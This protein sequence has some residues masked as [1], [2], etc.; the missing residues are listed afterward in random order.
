MKRYRIEVFD[1]NT[2]G[3]KCFAEATTPD[4]YIDAL[5]ASESSLT[6]K[7]VIDCKRGDFA[8][9][10]IDGKV[11]YQG[12][13]SDLTVDG[14]K[15]EVKMHQLIDMLNTEV[16]ADVSLLNSQTIE[17]WMK[18]LL[19]ATF[20]G[21][22]TFEQL[23]NLIVTTA[24][25]TSGAH[26]ESDNGVYN[27]YDLALYFFKIYGVIFDV[28]FDVNTAAVTI[29]MRSVSP[30]VMKLDMRV[31]D[32]S[33]YEI[34]NSKTTDSPS[35]VVVR[36]E[37]DP[38]ESATYYWHPTDFSGTI[39]TDPSTNRVVPVITRCETVQVGDDTTFADESYAKAEEILYATRY[40]DLINVTIK[41]ESK[42][43]DDW[44]IG[45]LY[46]L[47]DGETSYNTILTG[48]HTINMLYVEL[49]FGY[50]RKRL[51]QILKMKRGN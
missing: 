2:L 22:D 4:I 38:T 30:S 32:V 7:G 46:T 29:A 43:I 1:R 13:V 26:A 27:L 6:C 15:T 47:Y 8:Q 42:L 28:S 18:D 48:I 11:Y 49:T 31:S 21:S 24:S 25:S 17:Q 9:I 33:E 5:V 3:Y 12:T 36:N 34:E 41:A 16:F 19:L 23:P 10:R 14:N 20:K 37:E 40:D 45:Q 50:V 35:K 39:D 44:E 51:T